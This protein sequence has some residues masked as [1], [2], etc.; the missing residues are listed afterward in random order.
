MSRKLNVL[1]IDDDAITNFL[2]KRTLDSTQL[3]RTI[4]VAETVQEAI[5][6]L[7]NPGWAEQEK[8][9]LIFLDLNLPGLT[10][11]DFIEEYKKIESGNDNPPVIIIL[12]ASVNYDDEKKAKAMAE[13]AEFRRKPLTVEMLSEIIN[14]YF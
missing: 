7:K 11:W 2:H 8:T 3:T 9:E 10:G 13:V 14:S 12:S 4:Q 6:L 1:L 5:T